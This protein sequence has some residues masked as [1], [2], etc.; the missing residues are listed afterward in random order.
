MLPLRTQPRVPSAAEYIHEALGDGFEQALSA[1]DTRRRVETLI[2]EFLPK[3][4]VSGKT[5]LD[6]GC[7]L[8]FF[9]Q[10]L[11]A[12]GA[13][14]TA[15][16]IGPRLLERTKRRAGCETVLADALDLEGRFGCNQFDLVVSSECIEHTPDPAAALTQMLRVVRPG[17]Y[18]SVSTP[19]RVWRP[20]VRLATAT[21]QRP[22]EG[23]ENFST[24]SSMRRTIHAA[25][26]TI[27]RERGLH[28]VPFQLGLDSFSEW[29]DRRLQVLRGLMINICVLAQK[30]G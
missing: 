30:N 5:A 7:G 27:L 10:E 15:C 17:G 1:Y 6:V 14:V 21:G 24:W 18:V 12:R 3:D 8:G 4:V 11:V 9:S 29:C 23:L 19:N 2:G 16:D 13:T 26:G 20:V 25:G 28:L 22:F